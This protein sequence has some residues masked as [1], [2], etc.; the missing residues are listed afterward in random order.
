[1]RPEKLFDYLEG[2]FGAEERAAFEERLATDS[3]LQRE[4]AKGANDPTLISWPL[5]GQLNRE[6]TRCGSVVKLVECTPVAARTSS[7]M[8]VNAPSVAAPQPRLGST[9]AAE[10]LP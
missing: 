2:K 4:L 8:S 10:R 9:P 1:M 5:L 6:D 3:Q 7:G